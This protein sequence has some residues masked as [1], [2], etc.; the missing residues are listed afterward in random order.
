M[1]LVFHV[2]TL[3]GARIKLFV[4]ATRHVRAENVINVILI[5]PFAAFSTESEKYL[6][7]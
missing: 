4:S 6:Q 5:Q 2:I 1:I 3:R 7:R